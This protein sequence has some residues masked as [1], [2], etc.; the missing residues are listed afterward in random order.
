MG[1]VTGLVIGLEKES[2]APTEFWLGG[3]PSFS[4]LQPTVSTAV[5]SVAMRSS[6]AVL[7]L[8]NAYFLFLYPVFTKI[9]TSSI[10]TVCRDWLRNPFSGRFVK[11]TGKSDPC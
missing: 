11:I 9:M 6:D 10:E 3:A 7:Y 2:P 4:L 1:L 8:L 5:R